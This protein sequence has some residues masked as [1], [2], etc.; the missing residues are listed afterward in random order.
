MIQFIICTFCAVAT[1][2]GFL[3]H[4]MEESPGI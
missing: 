2:L 4:N 1:F 3:L